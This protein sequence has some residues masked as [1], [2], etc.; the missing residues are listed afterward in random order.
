MNRAHSVFPAIVKR[1]TKF[2]ILLA[3]VSEGVWKARV[4]VQ[5]QYY[6]STDEHVYEVGV[7]VR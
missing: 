4:L 1:L 5:K 7:Y 6:K 3:Q 2:W